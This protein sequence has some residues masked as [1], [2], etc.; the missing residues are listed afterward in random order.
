MKTWYAMVVENVSRLYSARVISEEN[1]LHYYMIWFNVVYTKCRSKAKS[2]IYPYIKAFLSTSSSMKNS[3]K[4][5]KCFISVEFIIHPHLLHLLS[6][7]LF[8]ISFYIRLLVLQ[9]CQ[10]NNSSYYIYI[11]GTLLLIWYNNEKYNSF[12]L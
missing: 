6:Q 7:N 12:R 3:N 11:L 2:Y 8:F 5:V 4:T 1:E 10:S 9:W